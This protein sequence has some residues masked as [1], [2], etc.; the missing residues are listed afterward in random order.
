MIKRATWHRQIRKAH[1]WLG[2]ILG[3]QFLFWTLG[4]I[5]FSW[6]NMSAVK[7]D[8]KR[9]LIEP[10]KATQNLV[11]PQLV[12]KKMNVKDSVQ[13]IIRLELIQIL[14][15]P[16]YQISYRNEHSERTIIQLADAESGNLRPALNEK[17]ATQV[18]AACLTA[19][20]RILKTEYLTAANGHHEYREQPL[21][22][23]AVTFDDND[24]ITVYVASELGTVQKLRNNKWRVYDLL[25][26]L[27]TMDYNTRS[28]FSNWL[29]QSFSV[30]GLITI[31]SGFILF[32]LSKKPKRRPI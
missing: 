32:Y 2:V 15:K 13:Y 9:A 26:M 21:P 20:L 25:W 3:V 27:H 28:N 17:E 30:L 29:I 4:G 8:D 23:Y 1:R 5:Y 22:A 14:S 7:G 19:N 11:S 6:S 12:I 16:Y 18:A 24:P 31:L 10:I